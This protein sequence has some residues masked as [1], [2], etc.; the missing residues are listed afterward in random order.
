MTSFS[1]YNG[2]RLAKKLNRHI[3]TVVLK[4]RKSCKLMIT[5][6]VQLFVKGEIRD[7][8]S[9]VCQRSPK[10]IFSFLPAYISMTLGSRFFML[11]SKYH[12]D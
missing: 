10:G 9:N 2:K 8:C 12:S 7:E 5:L 11:K 1:A 6:I 3:T 4:D